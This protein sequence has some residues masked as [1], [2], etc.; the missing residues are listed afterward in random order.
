MINSKLSSNYFTVTRCELKVSW[1]D[2][3]CWLVFLK[4]KPAWLTEPV[5]LMKS[6]NTVYQSASGSVGWYKAITKFEW[7]N[8]W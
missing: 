1:N 4:D 2:L 7:E 3:S 8:I 5:G 6:S